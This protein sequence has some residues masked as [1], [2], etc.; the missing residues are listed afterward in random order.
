MRIHVGGCDVLWWHKSA[1]MV[2][3]V[4]ALTASAV[5]ALALILALPQLPV[6]PIQSIICGEPSQNVFFPS[7]MTD[8][9]PFSFSKQETGE[10]EWCLPYLC[11]PSPS[12]LSSG[13]I[14]AVAPKHNTLSH[15]ASPTV[16]T[17][18]DSAALSSNLQESSRKTAGWGNKPVGHYYDANTAWERNCFLY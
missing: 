13:L 5:A 3:L 18:T 10:W 14:H 6:F 2:Q 12:L 9:C 1:K 16:E 17:C 7:T 11:P 15:W 8:F 4:G